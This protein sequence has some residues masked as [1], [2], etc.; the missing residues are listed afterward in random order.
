MENQTADEEKIVK[1]PIANIA[2][3]ENGNLTKA[4]E[5]FAKKIILQKMIYMLKIIMFMQKIVVKGKSISELLKENV[6]SIFK[7]LQGAH[8][9]RW[10]YNDEKFS[11]PIRWIVSILDDQ[12]V[13]VKIIDKESSNVSRGH[14]FSEQNIVVDNPNNY[15]ELLR[16]AYVIVD[17]DERKQIIVNKAKEAASTLGAEPYYTDDLLEEVTFITE[18]PVPAICEFDPRYLDIPEEVTVTVMAVHQRYFA[19]YKRRQTNQQIYYN[20]KLHRG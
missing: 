12:E 3:D 9:M 7:K 17:Q 11:R 5:G 13:K 20:D 10:G 16:K 15:K 19:L 18:Y 8:F 1:G 2:F 4:G 6:P 14:R